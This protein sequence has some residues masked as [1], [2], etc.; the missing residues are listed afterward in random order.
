MISEKNK[1]DLYIKDPI[2]KE[3]SFSNEKWISEFAFSNELLRLKEIKQLGVS[4]KTFP[5]ANHNRYMHSL[6]AY[7]I[8]LKFTKKL[9][10]YISIEDKKLFL[11]SAML[12]DIGH[13]PFSHVFEKI[14]NLDHEEMG[15]KIIC[16]DKLGIK[17]LLI[18]HNIS[19]KKITDILLGKTDKKWISRLISS[20]LDVDR[21]DYLFRDSYHI[22]TFYSTIDIDFLIER[23]EIFNDD[24]Y[25]YQNTINY[26]ES[27]LFGRYYMHLDIYDNKNSYIYEWSLA[28]IFER[29]KEL[30]HDFIKQKNKIYYYDLYE[31]LVFD[32]E[33]DVEK[34]ILLND[35]NLSSFIDSLQCLNDKVLNSF[36]FN[37]IYSNNNFDAVKYD[38][39]TFKEIESFFSKSNI[40]K[41]YLY[42]V[43]SKNSKKIY[44]PGRK[45]K[46]KI[47]DKHLNDTFDFDAKKLIELNNKSLVDSI[48]LIN[49]NFIN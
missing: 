14:S 45:N 34:Y 19:L 13:G 39:E 10:K 27:F 5:S 17:N 32:K 43:V 24:I 33:I 28:K 41:K 26:I 47:I 46:I 11:V 7:Q 15:R 16:S 44:Y 40:N 8:A 12:H 42:E 35:I 29:V 4:F 2:H 49:R 6:G 3:I 37:F 21:I 31:W 36:I 1:F 9:D 38:V 23:C 48:I 30:K 25:F 18:K 20:N 22:G